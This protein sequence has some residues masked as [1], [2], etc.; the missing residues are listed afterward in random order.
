MV[1]NHKLTTARDD[2]IALEILDT[3]SNV[4]SGAGQIILKS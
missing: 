2:V 3:A 1:Y 4:R